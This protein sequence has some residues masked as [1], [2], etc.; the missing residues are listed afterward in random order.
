MN[1][2]Y[3]LLLAMFFVS[4]VIKS[5]TLH[6]PSIPSSGVTYPFAIKY[7]TTSFSQQGP[8]DFSST[9]TSS[10]DNIQ[11]MP[12]SSSSIASN[13]PNATHVKYEDGN[14]FFIG[15]DSVSYTFHGEVSVLTSSY[16]SP[17][18]IH[19]YPFSLGN[20]HSDSELDISFTIPGGPPY[21]ERND[22]VVST[23]LSSGDITMPDGTLHSNAMLVHT[24]R[25]FTD[26]QIGSPACIT[27]LDA[28]HWWV[29][30]Y[31]VPVV[32]I[33]TMT[34]TGACPPSSPVKT[35]KFLV[36]DP[37]ASIEIPDNYTI[38]IYP[39]PSKDNI[40]IISTLNLSGVNYF[41]YDNLGRKIFNE[42][43]TLDSDVI[44]IRDLPKG[45]YI[46]T[47]TGKINKSVRFLKL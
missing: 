6:E 3:T 16:P 13:Y 4:L 41:I 28:Y 32:Q 14:Q 34:Q 33:S 47:I 35:S 7:D 31:A 25:T 12:I 11:I 20:V 22:Q 17:L 5:Q 46:L 36:G 40:H 29:M 37:F 44:N 8:W 15:F 24:I 38:S 42:V 9:T 18:I 2:K 26:G 27:T 10:N 21:L 43:K 30:G 19:P 45:V 23:A 1:N 39:N